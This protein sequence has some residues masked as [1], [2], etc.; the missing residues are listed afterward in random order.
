M[1]VWRCTCEVKGH[2]CESLP[3]FRHV[4]PGGQTQLGGKLLYSMSHLTGPKSFFFL[5]WTV[6]KCQRKT[7]WVLWPHS[8]GWSRHATCVVFP[9]S[10]RDAVMKLAWSHLFEGTWWGGRAEH[11]GVCSLSGSWR[12]G[13]KCG[14]WKRPPEGLS[15]N[16]QSMESWLA[17][18]LLSPL[19]TRVIAWA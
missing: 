16:S 6:H 13:E 1:L 4:S 3:S 12:C 19:S 18:W 7:M 15:E 8:P 14:R 11:Q 10:S 2:L 17:T 5:S 9:D